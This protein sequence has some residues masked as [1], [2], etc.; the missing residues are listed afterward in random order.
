MYWLSNQT[1]QGHI[2][3]LESTA[4]KKSVLTALYLIL[5]QYVIKSNDLQ[6][7]PNLY[8]RPQE[9][10][11]SF[12]P[13]GVSLVTF[14][15]MDSWS[16]SLLQSSQFKPHHKRCCAECK[17]AKKLLHLTVLMGDKT[18]GKQMNHQHL[19]INFGHILNH[20]HMTAVW[21]RHR[22]VGLHVLQV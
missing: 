22:P 9:A 13:L 8:W 10:E 1:K 14:C 7:S 17:G 5:Y 21:Q 4:L 2:K 16:S 6:Y 19:K 20:L 12:S 18:Y 15:T 3:N 11:K